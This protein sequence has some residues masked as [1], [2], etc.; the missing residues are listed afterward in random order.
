MFGR[1]L[2]T[3][4]TNIWVT[5]DLHFDHA[6]ILKFCPDTRPFNNVEDMNESLIEEWNS[7]VGENDII[8][9][10]GDFRLKRG[11]ERTEYLLSRL[12][13]MKVFVL[14][15]H[16]HSLRNGVSKGTHN[17]VWKGDYLELKINKQLVVFSHYPMLTWNKA[18]YGS[19]QLFG[20][21]HGSLPEQKGRQMDIGYD[22]LGGITKIDE[23]LDM[24]N[25]KP[26]Y[27]PD[28]H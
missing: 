9:H 5:S 24:C 10:G 1:K 2:N 20:H 3:Q 8:V 7:K 27:T 15:N 19:V 22:S 21:C 26:V 17:I 4:D 25:N 28:G 6:N 14:G 12:N 16:D 18:H 11:K 13:G 23:V